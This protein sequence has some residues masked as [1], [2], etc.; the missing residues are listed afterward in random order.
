MPQ[1]RSVQIESLDDGDVMRTPSSRLPVLVVDDEQSLLRATRVLLRSSGIRDVEAIHDSRKVLPFLAE[2]EVGVLVLDLTMPH[3]SGPELLEKVASEFPDVPVI[4]MT[5]VNDLEIAVKCM[6]LG[7]LDFL[8]KPVENNRFVSSVRR[9]MEIRALRAEVLSLKEHFLADELHNAEA[10]AGILTESKTMR[11]LFQYVEAI[12]ASHQPVLVT[13]ETGT[14]KD[15]FS[16]AIHNLSQCSGEFVAVNVAG[17]DDNVFSDTLFGHTKGA[18]TGAERARDGLIAQAAD[19]TL[20]LDEIGDLAES[21]QVKLLRLLQDYKYYPLGSDQP[22]QSNA[23]VVVATNHNITELIR[24]GKFRKDLYYRLRAHHMQIP[25]LRQRK[26]DLSLLVD[27]IVEKAAKSMDKRT[28]T[29]PPELLGLLKTYHFPGNVR[30]LE[31]MIYDAVARHR[32]GVL[33]LSSFRDAIGQDMSVSEHDSDGALGTSRL[34]S[35]FPDRL[36]TLAESEEFL[37]NEALERAG[38]NQGIAAGML[39]LTRQ[40]LNKRLVRRRKST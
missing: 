2:Q 11:S 29:L 7:A 36:P 10:F 30:E 35:L 8:V 37:I 3:I 40:A 34:E 15:L 23:R 5:A 24:E 28:P 22:R 4:I 20:F 26:E 9:A 33:S 31:A 25:P 1:P 39:G 38:G 18:F 13:G 27:H 12:A 6:R 14:G 21:S 19:G 17:L 16:V 32:G